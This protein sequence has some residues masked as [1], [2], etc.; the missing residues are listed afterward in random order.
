MPIGR[1]SGQML[2]ST[3]DR[4]SNLTFT[5]N[6][7]IP[8][9]LDFSASKVGINT[10]NVTETL[11]VD[12]TIGTNDG[13][14]SGVLINGTSISAKA[15]HVLNVVSGIDLGNLST[16][17]VHGGN[18]LDVL[19]T[20]G[21]GNL[22]WQSANVWLAD[23]NFLQNVTISGSTI[24]TSTANGNLVL[25][26][27]GTGE[28]T[29]PLMQVTTLNATNFTSGN[30]NGTMTGTFSGN[31]SG[32]FTGNVLTPSQPFITSLGTLTG[33]TLT[34]NIYA[35]GQS[36]I[37]TTRGPVYTN[38]IYDVSGNLTI[39]TQPGAVL[40]IDSTAAQV[41]PVGD[42]LQRPAGPVGSFRYNSETNAPEYYDGTAWITMRSAVDTQTIIG[43]NS[44]DT[45][46]LNY[47]TTQEG[48]IVSINGVV[49]TPGVAY[50]VD[51]DSSNYI[52]FLEVPKLGDT[53]E[54]RFLSTSIMVE[55]AQK[56]ALIVNSPAVNYGT[57]PVV[58]DEFSMSDF[59]SAKYTVTAQAAN[60]DLNMSEVMV[61]H[62]GITA[63]ATQTASAGVA[64]VV[65]ITATSAAGNVQVMAQSALSGALLTLYKLYFPLYT[66]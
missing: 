4:Q 3:L 16:V 55:M 27:N 37:A 14:G 30:I 9:Y 21:T 5:N 42:T 47:H 31:V 44:A 63:S 43:N 2:L 20:D 45:F 39:H 51:P 48:I 41:L 33:L 49:Q 64:N 13:A 52:L 12:G 57:S 19:T 53:I 32:D 7:S 1:I 58:I 35:P 10:D 28:V 17:H 22:T 24:S 11:T 26:G 8:M 36:V 65:V 62:N 66:I 61:M 25:Q 38:N 40:T 59:R 54:I 15:N 56:N 60:G 23:S 34:G 29:S 46:L 6:T 18:N 50:A